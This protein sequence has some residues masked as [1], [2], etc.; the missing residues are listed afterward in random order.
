MYLRICQKLIFAAEQGINMHLGPGTKYVHVQNTVRRNISLIP[1]VQFDFIYTTTRKDRDLVFV[2][3]QRKCFAA[4]KISVS[5]LKI[6]LNKKI[7]SLKISGTEDI[8]ES[9]LLKR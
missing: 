1:C 2:R 4:L 3:K 7:G 5:E 9:F 6:Y 8:G